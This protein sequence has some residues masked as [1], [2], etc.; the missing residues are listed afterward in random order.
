M[1][2][3]PTIFCACCGAELEVPGPICC[4]A[5]GDGAP[6]G[7]KCREHEEAPNV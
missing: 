7:T 3:R 5:R 6:F 4:P 2:D 1:S